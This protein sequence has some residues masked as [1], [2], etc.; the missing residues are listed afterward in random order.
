MRFIIYYTQQTEVKYLLC[1]LDLTAAFDTVDCGIPL[2]HHVH[3]MSQI[4]T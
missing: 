3:M 4:A 2:Y 1:L